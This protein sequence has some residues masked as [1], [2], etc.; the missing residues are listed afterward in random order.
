MN[1]AEYLDR[2]QPLI[3][4]VFSQS[5]IQNRLSHAYLIAG[6]NEAPL[7]DIA[8]YLAKSLVCEHPSPLADLSCLTCTRVDDGNYVDL[9]VYNGEEK[10]IRKEDVFKLEKSF[11]LSSQEPKGK[12]IYIIHHVENMTNEATNSL[13]KFL[14]EPEQEVYAFLTSLNTERLLPTIIS[15]CQL[16]NVRS[17]DPESVI[18]GAVKE[19]LSPE[20]SQILSN[21]HQ[22][23]AGLKKMAQSEEYA[24]VRDYVVS[25]LE[26]AAANPDEGMF[27]LQHEI[28]ENLS[29]KEILRFYIDIY[30]L[31]LYEAVVRQKGGFISLKSYDKLIKSLNDRYP[32]L[33][34]VLLETLRTRNIID[35]NVNTGLV[36]SHLGYLLLKGQYGKQQQ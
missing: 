21:F 4:R 17:V 23:I 9:V 24:I 3:K 33:V 13:L 28:I 26:K 22:N 35:L 32:S 16:L 10:T 31:F 7:L 30:S 18:A 11:S 14:E 6:S 34:D 36:L 29:G 5:V 15:R 20:D 27:Y 12:L 25:F 8:L 1:I 19:G 2:F